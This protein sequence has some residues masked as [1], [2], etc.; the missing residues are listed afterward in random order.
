MLSL[1]DRAEPGRPS[2]LP[3]LCGGPLGALLNGT[4]DA[5]ELVVA[6]LSDLSP[7]CCKILSGWW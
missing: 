5:C 2:P 6:I 4:G 7:A 3:D 1:F